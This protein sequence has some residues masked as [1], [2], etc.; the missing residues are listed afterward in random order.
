MA[1]GMRANTEQGRTGWRRD[2]AMGSTYL[3]GN[4]FA[5]VPLS[6]YDRLWSKKSDCL[7]RW[8]LQDFTEVMIGYYFQRTFVTGSINIPVLYREGP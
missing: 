1:M 2:Q 7:A 6:Y 3:G 4:T 8:K 5:S